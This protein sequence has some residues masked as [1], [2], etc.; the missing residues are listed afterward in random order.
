[1]SL[2]P[3]CMERS[4]DMIVSIMGILKAGGAYV[5]VEPD[6]PEER[7]RFMLKDTNASNIITL[8]KYADRLG[9]DPADIILLDD[10]WNDIKVNGKDNVPGVTR[11]DHPVY[12]IY[13]SGSTGQPKA[14]IVT[15]SNLTDYISG[16]TNTL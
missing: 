3:V 15:H 4:L 14:V 7:I 12:V 11:A 5:P 6:F 13:T 10:N 9:A 16:L 1:G 8:S 2:V